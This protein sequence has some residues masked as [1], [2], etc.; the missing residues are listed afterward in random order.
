MAELSEAYEQQ[1]GESATYR[2]LSS[3]Y[4]T[5]RYVRWLEAIATPLM[6]SKECPHCGGDG[7]FM[8]KGESYPCTLCEGSGRVMAVESRTPTATTEGW[9]AVE[10]GLPH[11][12]MWCALLNHGNQRMLG[13]WNATH[14]CWCYRGRWRQGI[15]AW[16]PLPEAPPEA[17]CG[18]CGQRLPDAPPPTGESDNG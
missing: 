1:V 2:K 9:V 6:K 16:L 11:D 8:D 15:A 17:V 10:D 14:E 13:W 5:L 7:K 12:D 4:H 3:T 18:E